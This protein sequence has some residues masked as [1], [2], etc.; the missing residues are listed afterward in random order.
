MSRVRPDY[1][2]SFWRKL[3]RFVDGTENPFPEESGYEVDNEET[4]ARIH[5]DFFNEAE[6]VKEQEETEELISKYDGWA[7]KKGVKIYEKIYRIASVVLCVAIIAFL[8]Y[9]VSGLPRFGQADNP[10]NN[11]VYER[12]TEKGIEETGAVN[13][14]AGMILDYRAFDTL[15]ESHVLFIATVCV[16]ILLR[17]DASANKAEVEAAEADD[18][19]FEPKNDS[20]LRHSA[21]FLVPVI[22]LF[23]I[24]VI[25]NGHLSA[26]GGFSGGAIIGAGLIL[27]LNAY[28][29]K[30]TER[31]FTMKTFKI[32]S[33]FSLLFYSISKTYSF[34]TGA[35]ELESF[36]SNGTP[37]KILSSGLI[38]PLNVCVGMVVACT[39]YSFYCLFRKGGL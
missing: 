3:V 27:Y 24:Y 25:L 29:F 11:E 16:L 19:R 39:I 7:D 14:V 5:N 38:L 9:T 26:G 21:N 31:F 17:L 23:G 33:V 12:Y 8:L 15:G 37:G 36:I 34:F 6:W 35:N 18:R 2:N 28:G 22:I 20:L 4:E 10:V 30:K 32:I 13:I 1:E